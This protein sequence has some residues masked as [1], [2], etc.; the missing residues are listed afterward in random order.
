MNSAIIRYAFFLVFAFGFLSNSQ[1]VILA[2]LKSELGLSDTQVG[3]VFTV[4]AVAGVG[5][6]VLAGYLVETRGFRFILRL[7]AVVFTIAVVLYGLPHPL[8]SFW[9]V[10]TASFLTMFGLNGF[11]FAANAVVAAVSGEQKSRYLN[12]LHVFYCV[13]SLISPVFITRFHLLIP[14]LQAHAAGDVWRFNFSLTILVAFVCLYGAW[15]ITFPPARSR[16]GISRTDIKQVLYCPQVYW[17]TGILTAYLAAEL[18]FSNWIVLYLKS[19]HVPIDRA[20]LYLTCFFVFMAVGR[21]CG[22]M[23]LTRRNSDRAVI[24]FLVAIAVSLLSG[25]FLYRLLLPLAGLFFSIIFPTL[26]GRAYQDIPF[27]SFFSVGVIMMGMT[28]GYGLSQALLGY[29]NDCYSVT[30]VLPWFTVGM[31]VASVILWLAYL[32]LQSD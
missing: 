7:A 17:Y 14:S 16:E 3:F 10:L 15:K 9:L 19:D 6:P 5:T 13:G 31:A 32:R 12:F 21:L 2:Y 18:S 20:S 27:K 25:F 24:F 8:I 28:A 30:L 26:V 11:S 4:G 1:P 22:G 29:L 23:F